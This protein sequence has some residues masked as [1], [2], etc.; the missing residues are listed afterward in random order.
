[1]PVTYLFHR[2]S[3]TSLRSS[4][5]ESVEENGR[6][7]HRFKQGSRLRF[8]TYSLAPIVM[9]LADSTTFRISFAK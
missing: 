1:M 3:G 5:Y 4:I 7:Y 6:G 8:T 2:T 9:S